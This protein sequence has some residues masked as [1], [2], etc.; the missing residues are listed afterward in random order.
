MARHRP[1]QRRDQAAPFTP[2]EDAELARMVG[3]GLASD[4]WH[5]GLPGRRFG[6]IAER[7]LQLIEAGAVRRP[8][9]I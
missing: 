4:F 7:R 8:A 6:E 3:C 9:L 1:H 5:V 2:S